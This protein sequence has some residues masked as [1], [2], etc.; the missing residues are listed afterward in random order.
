MKKNLLILFIALT[1]AI[2]AIAYDDIDEIIIEEDPY[3]GVTIDFSEFAPM[4]SMSNLTAKLTPSKYVQNVDRLITTVAQSKTAT[5]DLFKKGNKK[6]EYLP[7]SSKFV[8]KKVLKTAVYKNNVPDEYTTYILE[9]D[10]GQ[11]YALSDMEL[12]DV[13]RVSLNSYELGLLEQFNR[14]GNYSRVILY[15]SK[16]PLYKDKKPPYS[17]KDLTSV[18]DYFLDQI[19]D[20]PKDTILMSKRNFRLSMNI[21]ITTLVYLISEFDNLYLEDIEVVSMPKKQADEES[22]KHA[23]IR[24]KEKDSSWYNK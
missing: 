17:E 10:I 5:K 6:L 8:V 12:K 21:P 1:M 4:V 3:M 18:F 13:S 2:P 19:K 20:Y 11:N 15:F 23:K 24:S 22:Y 9:N 7:A 16:P 14:Q